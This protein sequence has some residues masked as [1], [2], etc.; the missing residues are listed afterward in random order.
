SAR[1]LMVSR[2]AGRTWTE[3]A[4]LPDGLRGPLAIDPG[5]PSFF[6]AGLGETIHRSTD[7]GRSWQRCRGPRGRA[8]G[9]HF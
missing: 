4:V 2:D 3:H 1:R 9:F 8:L 7:G 5:N 6:L